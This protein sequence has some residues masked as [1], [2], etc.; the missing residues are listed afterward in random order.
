MIRIKHSD[1]FKKEKR[2]ELEFHNT[3]L[4]KNASAQCE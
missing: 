4:C 1:H 3:F 2:E